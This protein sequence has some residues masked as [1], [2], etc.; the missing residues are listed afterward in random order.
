M[1]KNSY[2]FHT[3]HPIAEDYYPGNQQPNVHLIVFL[4]PIFNISKGNSFPMD[5]FF[6]L[7][8]ACEDAPTECLH[9]K[10]KL[11]VLQSKTALMYH[12]PRTFSTLKAI[13]SLTPLMTLNR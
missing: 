9:N 4:L 5:T 11:S 12:S 8:G 3:F 2:F 13:E 7:G 6:P 10:L 1:V